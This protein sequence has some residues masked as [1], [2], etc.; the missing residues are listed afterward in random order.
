MKLCKDCKF[1]GE[2][3]E[4]WDSDICED[5]PS[6]F[7]ECQRVCHGNKDCYDVLEHDDSAIVVDGSGY[8]AALRVKEDFGCVYFEK[9]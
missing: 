9:K 8:F 3:I 1:L 7:H 4:V 6:G 2:E 5:K